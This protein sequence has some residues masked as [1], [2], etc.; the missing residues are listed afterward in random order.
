VRLD[1]ASSARWLDGWRRERLRAED[2]RAPDPPAVRRPHTWL[3]GVGW[4]RLRLLDPA[5]VPGAA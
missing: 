3:L 4:R 5:G 2:A 1:P